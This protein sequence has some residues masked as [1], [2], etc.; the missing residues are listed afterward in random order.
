VPIRFQHHLDKYLAEISRSKHSSG[1]NAESFLPH[2]GLAWSNFLIGPQANEDR[3]YVWKEP[4]AHHLVSTF[5]L[6]PNCK[7]LI[8]LR[9]GRD[10]IS[11]ALEAEFVLSKRN[12]INPNH[13]RRLLPDADFHILCQRFKQAVEEFHSE[14]KQLETLGL[15]EH[16]KLVRF[17]DLQSNSRSCVPEIMHFLRLETEG[18]SWSK[19]GQLAVRGSSFLTNYRGEMDF[20]LGIQKPEGFNPVGRWRDWGSRRIKYFEKH[21]GAFFQSLGYSL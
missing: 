21:C 7:L 16:I 20:A 4:S 19:H 18:F 11:S 1:F 6:F 12:L 17:E 3:I 10:V 15:K 2:L 5:K 13:W 9:D 14:L 8:L